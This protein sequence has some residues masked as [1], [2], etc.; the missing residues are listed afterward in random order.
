MAT[1]KPDYEVLEL[2]GLWNST[3]FP[4]DQ[5]LAV[6]IWT[7]GSPENI[8]LNE[9]SDTIILLFRNQSNCYRLYHVGTKPN[10]SIR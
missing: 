7:K 5:P 6:S 10:F 4:N 9:A 1:V 3:E 2:L 8:Y